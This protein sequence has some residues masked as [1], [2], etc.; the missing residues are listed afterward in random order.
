MLYSALET[1][2]QLGCRTMQLLTEN[3]MR[4]RQA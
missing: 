2:L 4:K 3:V 1:E